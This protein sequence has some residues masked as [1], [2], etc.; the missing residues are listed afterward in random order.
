MKHFLPFIALLVLLPG[1]TGA[2]QITDYLDPE[3]I[4][5]EAFI[6]G[7]FNSKSGNQDQSS[8][9]L[10][11]KADYE[12]NYSTLPRSWRFLA[13]G[14][15]DISRGSNPA[16]E[17]QERT[18][19]NAHANIDSYFLDNHS[20]FWFGSG[21]VG[22]QDNA[23]N[24][25]IKFGIG[26]GY[27][28]VI[29]A[30]P[31]ARF[32]R[33]EDEL[34]EHGVVLGKISDPAYLD[35]ARIIA[36]EDEFRSRYGADEYKSYWFEAVEEQLQT[37]V[38]LRTDQLGALGALEMNRVLSDEVIKIRKHGWLLRAGLG[39]IVQDFQ[40]NHNDPSI[41]LVWE[42][43]RPQ[44]SK[45][46]YINTMSYSKIIANESGT[47]LRN[48]MSYTWEISDLIDWENRWNLIIDKTNSSNEKTTTHKL[49]SSFNYYITNRISADA[50]ISAINTEDNINDNGNDETDIV[51]FMG[52]RYRLK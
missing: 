2:I 30:T 39:L 1:W 12:K 23:D 40:G 3:S 33:V 43:A 28:R 46:Q 10:A 13:D 16:V 14:S 51:T 37:A 42:Y 29:N 6:L 15:T 4:Y 11:L 47:I 32:L 27:G 22:Y 45:G 24:E 49:S 9:D 7:Q 34:R 36:R 26:I 18:F 20:L 31:L 41:D 19:A 44:G 25:L 17:R 8:Y 35:M 21:D 5:E 48:D 50:T 52:V 38:V